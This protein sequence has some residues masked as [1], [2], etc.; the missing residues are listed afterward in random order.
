MHIN[1]VYLEQN[2]IEQIKD[3]FYSNPNFGNIRLQKFISE[4]SFS[5]L[6]R[7]V[8]DCAFKRLETPL[9][10]SYAV[11]SITP[12]LQRL[13]EES[14]LLHFVNL[15]SEKSFKKVELKLIQLSWKDFH[16]LLDTQKKE[17]KD[18][19]EFVIDL[20]SQWSDEWGGIV[21]YADNKG[22]TLEI[23]SA[24]NSIVVIEKKPDVRS[25]IKYVNHYA[26]LKRTL[27]FGTLR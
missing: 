26:N 23:P 16:M 2:V 19:F 21:V 24:Q 15:I 4:E 6:K 13:I 22:E 14:D 17:K 20:S 9:E 11:A 3:A 25:F 12:Q 5:Q 7:M 10:S 27:L 1:R 18:V 8:T